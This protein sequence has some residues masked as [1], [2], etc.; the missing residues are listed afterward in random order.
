[1][2]KGYCDRH[3][4][5]NPATFVARCENVAPSAVWYISRP[6]G[7]QK[8]NATIE[9][10]GK[11]LAWLINAFPIPDAHATRFIVVPMN[12]N[13]SRLPEPA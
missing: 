8:L 1:M 2:S 9:A 12:P 10:C 5:G 6:D 3:L 4:C 7:T 11:H 13:V